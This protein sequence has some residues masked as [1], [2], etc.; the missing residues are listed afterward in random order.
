[1]Q[2]GGPREGRPCSPGDP[3]GPRW[4]VERVISAG[5]GAL[6][7]VKRGTF[8]RSLCRGG[9]AQTLA[10]RREW[11][12]AWKVELEAGEGRTGAGGGRGV[13]GREDDRF[14]LGLRN[15]RSL[16]PRPVCRG[17]AADTRQQRGGSV[18]YFK[19]FSC[20]TTLTRK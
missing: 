4:G 13:L 10:A 18:Q 3:S 11:L 20:L 2:P 19:C 7:K 6:G 5:F 1:M 14:A 9:L 17:W 15:L 12:E 16:L 8:P